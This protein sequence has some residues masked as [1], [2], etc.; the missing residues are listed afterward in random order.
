[1]EY[2]FGVISLLV[3]VYLFL[4]IFKWD[5]LKDRIPR[6]GRFKLYEWIEYNWGE[7]AARVYLSVLCIAAV[8]CFVMA[9]LNS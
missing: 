6:G 4:I 2:V 9:L 7:T 5:W 1:M 8:F 3:M